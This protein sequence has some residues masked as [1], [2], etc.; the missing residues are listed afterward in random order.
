MLTIKNY[1][2]MKEAR[3][4]ALYIPSF[5]T[6]GNDKL[7]DYF[8]EE[9]GIFYKYAQFNTIARRCCPFASAG[10]LN[11][12][13]ACAGR[14]VMEVV[15]QAR[16]R[17]YNDSLRDDFAAGMIYT[18]ETELSSRRYAGAHMII[19]IHESGDF[20]SAEYLNKWF[21]VFRHFEND[22]RVTFCFYTKSFKF[23]LDASD[24]DLNMLCRCLEKNVCAI[25]FSLDDTTTPEQI[26]RAVKLRE[27]LPLANIYYCTENV[28]AI[29]HDN[30][31]DC[32]DCAKCGHC[33]KTE[34]KTTVVKIHSATEK[35]LAKYRRD[36]RKGKAA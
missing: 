34:G 16:E 21:E 10:C 9:T 17:A 2:T 12:C 19:R 29:K 35:Q 28:D 15:K 26:A 23:F 36:S 13:Y 25:S 3:A 4:D 30:V 11:V 6:S 31:C 8:N 27:R 22:S 7:K 24:D 14:H 20:Y 1:K 18:I 5:Q 32:A 33:T